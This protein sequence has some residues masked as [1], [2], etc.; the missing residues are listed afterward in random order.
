[1]SAVPDRSNDAP[2]LIVGAPRSG[3]TL[4][5]T[6]L[7]A[8]PRLYLANETK[9]LIDFL[10]DD[11]Y[12]VGD[13]DQTGERLV[14]A[15]ESRGIRGTPSPDVLANDDRADM[16]TLIRRLFEAVAREHGKERWGEK[17][18]VAYRRLPAIHR[19][20]PDA[21]Y[22]GLH[23]SL[24]NVAASYAR[25]NPQWGSAGGLLHWLDFHRAVARQGRDFRFHLVRYEE[26]VSDTA[27][28]LR[29][30]CD[31]VGLDYDP[32][33]LEHHRT[34]RAKRLATAPEFAGAARPVH[35]PTEE[36]PPLPGW[37][38]RSAER[39]VARLLREKRPVRRPVWEPV[40]RT[41]VYARLPLRE[42]RAEGVGVTLRKVRRALLG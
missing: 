8:H 18:A 24:S 27:G 36:A 34:E 26:L 37:M 25:I 39:H 19:A 38:L 3:T 17:T 16:A 1:M 7:N 4:L 35:R 30:V 11:T 9:L 21:L 15:A 12:P 5:A 23:R 40:L 6:M 22:I 28:T 2:I 13:P 14:Q 33:M 10:P 20:F 32:V 42:A 41:L 29:E 31:F